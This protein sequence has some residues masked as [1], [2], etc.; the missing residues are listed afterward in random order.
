MVGRYL[1]RNK[2]IFG[3]WNPGND[4]EDR[5]I[6]KCP[7]PARDPIGAA[8]WLAAKHT[9]ALYD[10]W[11]AYFTPDR[12]ADPKWVERAYSRDLSWERRPTLDQTVA[13]HGPVDLPWR[14]QMR[15]Q[16][17][18]DVYEMIPENPKVL[19]EFER[20]VEL[21][22]TP[23]RDLTKPNDFWSKL[24]EWAF[25]DHPPP[26]R[27]RPAPAPFEVGIDLDL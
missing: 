5:V 21:D 1:N 2:P 13:R 26:P 23:V 10:F 12:F 6:G 22:T 16:S 11:A 15:S 20:T 3:W 7:D 19:V 9:I 18:L 14:V 24:D 4:K 8:D 27:P 17:T 25:V